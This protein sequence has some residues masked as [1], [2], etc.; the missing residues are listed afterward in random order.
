VRDGRTLLLATAAIEVADAS[1]AA[2]QDLAGG[3]LLRLEPSSAAPDRY[4]RLVAFAFA[5]E[6]WL[7]LQ[8]AL[9]AQ[10]LARVAARAGNKAGADA[11]LAAIPIFA[12]LHLKIMRACGRN[13]GFTLIE[14]K[15]LSVRESGDNIYICNIYMYM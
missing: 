8:Q 9:L 7:S 3:R 14:G 2:L 15:V 6:G 13:G 4:G 5:G 1:R 11:L 10:G 12:P